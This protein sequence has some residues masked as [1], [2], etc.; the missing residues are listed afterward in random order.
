MEVPQVEFRHESKVG[1]TSDLID[2]RGERR[3]KLEVEI[4]ITSKSSGRLK[5]RTGDISQSG[6]SALLR[7]ELTVGELVELDFTVPLGR[8]KIYAIVANRSAFR[9]GFRFAESRFV[10]EIIRPTC[11]VLGLEQYVSDGI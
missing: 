6:I 5:G 8:V 4:Q 9:Y 11:R 1:A 2:R 10:E 7:E 3:F